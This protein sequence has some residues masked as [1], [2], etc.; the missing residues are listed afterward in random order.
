MVK[1]SLGEAYARLQDHPSA[2]KTFAAAAAMASGTDD[3]SQAAR[4]KAKALYHLGQYEGCLEACREALDAEG[5]SE[6]S[7]E[8]LGSAYS[9]LGRHDAAVLSF[10][11]AW[12]LG[13]HGQ[14]SVGAAISLSAEFLAQK[15]NEEALAFLQQ[16][17]VDTQPNGSFYI[18]L[19]AALARTG[20]HGGARSTLERAATLGS[21]RAKELIKRWDASAGGASWI[22]FWFGPS[23]RT[24]RL[25]GTTLFVLLLI[26][27]F[28]A[29]MSDALQPH[30]PWIRMEKNWQVMLIP[31]ALL[32]ILLALPNLKGVKF[33]GVEIEVTQPKPETGSPDIDFER[34]GIMVAA[35]ELSFSANVFAT[36]ISLQQD[37]DLTRPPIPTHWDHPISP[38]KV[39]VPG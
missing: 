15:K 37:L 16:A 10:R 2:L 28:P 27:L 11:R 21:S 12:R 24:H 32:S 34:E 26:A 9:A 18:N 29:L 22:G 31:I 39:G 7:L 6:S 19:A 4:G 33:A 25:I 1:I 8:L 5:E 23:P 3:R 38:V 17:E 13:T 36:A 30:F 14:R 20:N 35:P